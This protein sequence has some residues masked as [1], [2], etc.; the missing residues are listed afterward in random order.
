MEIKRILWP[1]D[2]SENAA[3]A[4]PYVT[5]F[6]KSFSVRGA[7]FMCS[8]SMGN[9]ELLMETSVNL[10]MRKCM[11]GSEKQQRKGSVRFAKSF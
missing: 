3:K 7:F 10:I 9:G 5:F 1:T 6:L 8:K 4:L 2:F 11:N